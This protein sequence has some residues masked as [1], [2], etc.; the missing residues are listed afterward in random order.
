MKYAFAVAVCLSTI[1]A[2]SSA[3]AQDRPA[4]DTL[5]YFE[6]Q[7]DKTVE[8]LPGL[9]GPAYPQELRDAKVSGKVLVQFVVDTLGRPV[10]QSFKVVRSQHDLFTIAVK[11]AVTEFRYAPAEIEGRKVKQ[12]VQQPFNFALA[13]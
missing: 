2:P 13:K 4:R 9:K 10:M 12:L 6:F 5:P 11:T 3:L 7:V 1:F 8:P